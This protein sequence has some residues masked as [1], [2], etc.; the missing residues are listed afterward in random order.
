M[1]HEDELTLLREETETLAAFLHLLQREY[2]H[3]QA[4]FTAVLRALG[5][6]I[7][8]PSTTLQAPSHTQHIERTEDPVTGAIT[9]RLRHDE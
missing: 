8:V 1:P 4:D 6:Q 2:A 7:E 5:E 9:F 3:L